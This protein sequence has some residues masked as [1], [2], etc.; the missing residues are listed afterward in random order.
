[1]PFANVLFFLIIFGFNIIYSQ[2]T[3]SN[4]AAIKSTVIITFDQ[5]PT[6]LQIS[7]AKLKYN[8][9][10]A[11]SFTL[12]DGL[13]SAY[14]NIFPILRGGAKASNGVYYNGFSYTDG[15]GHNIPFKAGIAW[16]SANS[17]GEDLHIDNS[18]GYMSWAQLDEL[19]NAGW[20]VLNH[21]Y[22]HKTRGYN[23]LGLPNPSLADQVYDEEIKANVDRVAAMTQNKIEM[24]HFVVPSGDNG[25]YQRAF[26]NGMQAVYDQNWQ[27]LGQGA[28][29]SVD[30]PL[31]YKD[32]V[33]NRNILS[34]D[35]K[36]AN[37]LLDLTAS[38]VLNETRAYWVSSFT[39]DVESKASTGGTDIDMVVK[40]MTYL[41]NTYGGKGKDIMW[42]APLQEVFEYLQ[43]RD[44]SQMTW[45]QEGNK[46]YIEFDLSALPI[47]LRRAALTLSIHTSTP[48]RKVE[49][50]DMS[51]TSFNGISNTNKIINL[52][53]ASHLKK[54]KEQASE[55]G[56]I[57]SLI[58][59]KAVAVPSEVYPNPSEDTIFIKSKALGSKMVR[60]TLID[61]SG[62]VVDTETLQAQEGLLMIPIQK[63]NSGSYTL[64]MKLDHVDFKDVK[65]TKGP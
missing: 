34:N 18:A 15:C 11:Y 61:A 57:T 9:E 31:D 37:D 21:S 45:R 29:L 36:L 2:N 33:M 41:N 3:P 14:S 52:D 50:S 10:F 54:L 17:A 19:Y 28:G 53:F 46:V 22:S 20:D 38:T 13:L 49:V 60:I 39:H 32:F 55:N 8:K 65:F 42:M 64:R 43:C 47:E 24:T 44:Y 27:I 6:D 48:F 30:D 16:N 58:D 56:G 26:A 62:K 7:K 12:D 1:M 4:T 23:A 59:P 5:A 40:H 35:L 25:Y 51:N 63:L